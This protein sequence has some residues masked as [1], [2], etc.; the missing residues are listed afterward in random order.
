MVKTGMPFN[1]KVLRKASG[2]TGA[3]EYSNRS[4][5]VYVVVEKNNGEDLGIIIRNPT[6]KDLTN[7]NSLV[8]EM[9]YSFPDVLE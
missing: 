7:I 8:L 1:A 2:Y 4:Q 9:N 5:F 6:V 3:V